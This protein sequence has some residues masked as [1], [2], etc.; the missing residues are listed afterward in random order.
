MAVLHGENKM[1]ITRV[2]AGIKQ[3]LLT[4]VKNKQDNH[5]FVLMFHEITTAETPVY[6]GTAMTKE[7]FVRLL[8]GV[9]KKGLP[10]VPVSEIHNWE[11]PGVV[12]TFDDIFQSAYENAFPALRERG[13]PYTVFISSA[14]VDQPGFIT[15]AQLTELKEDRL[16]TIGFHGREHVLMRDLTAEQIVAVT[17]ACDFEKN[18]GVKCG[19]FAFPYGSVYA[20]PAK[21][22]KGVKKHAYRGV[23]STIN[24]ATSVKQIRK[25]PWFIPRINMND[26]EWAGVLK[27]M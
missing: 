16:C 18:Y 7:A 19:Y 24:S 8:D 27:K 14:L 20:C 11:K 26:A 10:F 4:H 3:R 1:I 22:L 15:S 12:L 13:I 17:D 9:E 21:A 25:D 23:F 5:L 6:P 2:L